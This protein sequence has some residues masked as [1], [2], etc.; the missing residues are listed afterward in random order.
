MRDEIKKKNM[1]FGE[2]VGICNRVD[3]LGIQQTIKKIAKTAYGLDIV[4]FIPTDKELMERSLMNQNIMDVS[5]SSAYQ[6]MKEAMKS[7]RM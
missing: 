6:S 5:N 7:L 2:T 4:G 1:N 3:D